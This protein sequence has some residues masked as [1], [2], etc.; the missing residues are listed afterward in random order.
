MNLFEMF[1]PNGPNKPSLIDALRD[2]L[3]LAIKY[4]KL[5]HIPKIKLVKRLTAVIN[6]R[7]VATLLTIELSK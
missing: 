7:S 4:L 6:Q 2:F 5:N 3:P 1:D